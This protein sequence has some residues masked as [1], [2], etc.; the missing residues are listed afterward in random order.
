M[1]ILKKIAKGLFLFIISVVSIGPLFWVIMSAFKTNQEII[2]SAFSLPTSLNFDGFRAA[3]ELAPIAQYYGNSIIISV[4]ATFF[5]VLLVSMAAYAIVRFSFKGK[6]ALMTGLSSSLLVPTSAILM[7]LYIILTSMYL[8][9]TKTGL[10]IVYVALGLPTSLFIMRS[11]F[12]GIPK[13]IE[14]AAYVDGCGFFKTFFSIVLPVAKPGL[15]T[16][17]TLQ[18]LMCWNEFMFALILTKSPT[19]RTLPLALNYFKSQFSFNYSA[20]FAAITMVILPSIVAYV[21]LQE[22]VTE[23]LVAGSLKG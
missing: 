15:A 23:S 13:E 16:V 18:F 20:M 7:P 12:L 5:N 10:I 9:D 2:N 14:E 11:H 17:A 22:Q 8:D 3:L 19:V 6:N 4:L 1:S 21:V